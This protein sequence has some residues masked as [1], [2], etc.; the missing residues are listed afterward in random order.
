[1]PGMGRD[2]I[3]KLSVI[4]GDDGMEKAAKMADNTADKSVKR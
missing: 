4:M 1:M 3:A 2:A